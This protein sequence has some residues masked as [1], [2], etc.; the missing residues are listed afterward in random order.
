MPPDLKRT[1]PHR[2]KL[3]VSNPPSL[4]R[5]FLFFLALLAVFDCLRRSAVQFERAWKRTKT[6]WLAHNNWY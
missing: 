3:N 4:R 2:R 6:F 1:S 5:S